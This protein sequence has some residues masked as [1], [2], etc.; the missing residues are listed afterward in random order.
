MCNELNIYFFKL[1]L[2]YCFFSVS[3]LFILLNYDFIFHLHKFI[4]EP[5]NNPFKSKIL[6]WKRYIDDIFFVWTGTAEELMDFLGFINSTTDFLRFTM[7]YSTQK[8]NFLDLTIYKNEFGGLDTTIYRKPLS[9]NTLLRADSHH[10]KQLINNIPIGQFLRLKRKCSTDDEFVL[11]AGPHVVSPS[12]RHRA[13]G[14]WRPARPAAI[15]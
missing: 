13:L 11:K 15:H 7:E 4:H 6:L 2:H 3:H 1:L 9:R 8:I 14:P 12:A 10:P 5:V